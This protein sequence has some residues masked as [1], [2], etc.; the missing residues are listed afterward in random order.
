MAA[1][2]LNLLLV[3]SPEP[4]HQTLHARRWLWL[5]WIIFGAPASGLGRTH[6]GQAGLRGGIEKALVIG[7][8]SGKVPPDRQR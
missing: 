8:E 7:D 2:W 1:S 3:P 5:F 4:P 6:G